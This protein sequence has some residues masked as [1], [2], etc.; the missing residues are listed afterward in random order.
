MKFFVL[1]ADNLRGGF[2]FGGRL[3]DSLAA[4]LKE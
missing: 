1:N 4:Q 2:S 3:S